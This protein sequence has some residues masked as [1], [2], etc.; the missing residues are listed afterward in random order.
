M[1]RNCAGRLMILEI[2]NVKHPKLNGLK[3][4]CINCLTVPPMLCDLRK[5]RLWT[6]N[7]MV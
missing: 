5:S 3:D 4:Y 7:L 6:L 1:K 2:E